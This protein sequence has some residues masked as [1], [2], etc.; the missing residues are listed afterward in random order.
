MAGEWST[1]MGAMAGVCRDIRTRSSPGPWGRLT[2]LVAYLLLLAFV[3][4]LPLTGT[5][6]S[7]SHPG[8][9]SGRPQRCKDRPAAAKVLVCVVAGR[10]GG[11]GPRRAI[12]PGPHPTLLSPPVLTPAIVKNLSP[13]TRSFR[14]LRC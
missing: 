7:A 3:A 14:P 9:K 10:F 2:R 1:P 8:G 6:R 12:A 13:L 4:P 11:P 5:A